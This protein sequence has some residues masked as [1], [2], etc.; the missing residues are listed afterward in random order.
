VLRALSGKVRA[1]QMISLLATVDL[2]QLSMESLLK[3]AHDYPSQEDI[4]TVIL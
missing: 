1:D 2:T 4:L 3:L